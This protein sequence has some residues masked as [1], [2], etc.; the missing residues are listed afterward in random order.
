MHKMMQATQAKQCFDIPRKL[1]PSAQ[2]HR[3]ISVPIGFD[4]CLLSSFP[5]C[6]EFFLRPL[7][8][9]QALD[10]AVTELL[11]TPG[12]ISCCLKQ[13]LFSH[14]PTWTLDL[15]NFSATALPQLQ[16]VVHT[17]CHL[18]HRDAQIPVEHAANVKQCM[19]SLFV[20]ALV[21]ECKC[22]I[23][24]CMQ[25]LVGVTPPPPQ[26]KR[27]GCALQPELPLSQVVSEPLSQCASESQ[28]QP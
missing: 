1:Q 16:A 26:K 6:M 23:V 13:G 21:G 17:L 25:E 8:Q 5:F 12:T 27:R 24:Q 28:P 20:C 14:T 11:A 9:A 3:F 18:L 7:L 22:A 4:T 15:A 2:M 19:C 10:S